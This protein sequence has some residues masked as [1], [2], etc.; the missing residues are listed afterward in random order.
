MTRSALAR[1][2]GR[3]AAMMRVASSSPSALRPEE[4]GVMTQSPELLYRVVVALSEDGVINRDAPI[5][6]HSNMERTAEIVLEQ[7]RLWDWV[8]EP[9]RSAR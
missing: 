7:R 9:L 6:P 3:W 4:L 8:L 5:T 1:V 2:S